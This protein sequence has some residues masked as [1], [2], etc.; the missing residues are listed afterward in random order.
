[1]RHLETY[2]VNELKSAEVVEGSG[3]PSGDVKKLQERV[4]FSHGLEGSEKK[5][6]NTGGHGLHYKQ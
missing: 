1:M 6:T 3:Y 5:D 4:C 2:N